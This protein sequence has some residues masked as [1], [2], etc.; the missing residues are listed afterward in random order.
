[1][2]FL[3]LCLLLLSSV[4]VEAGTVYRHS[5]DTLQKLYAEL[6]YLNEAGREI[7]EKYDETD[8]LQMKACSSEYGYIST[9]AKATIGIANRI[10]SPNKQEYIDTGWYAYN[11]IRCSGDVADCDHIPPTLETIETEFRSLQ[12]SQ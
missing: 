9:R 5:G 8:A 2:R 1:M 7:H 4:M 10:D 12:S 6:H 11:C 3:G